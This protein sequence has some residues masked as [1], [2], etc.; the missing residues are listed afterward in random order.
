M[1]RMILLAC[2]AVAACGTDGAPQPPAKTGLSL[3][4]EAQV[5]VV[6]K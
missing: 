1:P 4:G 3:S 5:G 6:I 2:L